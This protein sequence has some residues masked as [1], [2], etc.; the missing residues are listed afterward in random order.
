M[1]IAQERAHRF[2]EW[3]NSDRVFIDTGHDVK[4]AAMPRTDGTVGA[5]VGHLNRICGGDEARRLFIKFT[6]D[7]DSSRDLHVRDRNALMAWLAPK[8][9]EYFERVPVDYE[10]PAFDADTEKGQWLCRR[11]CA[12]TAAA[13]IESA[14]LALRQLMMPIKWTVTHTTRER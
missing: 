14:R 7:V 2:K 11:Q 5:L 8:H 9:F 4:Y 3:I 12:A 1:T 6:F 10:S 13:V